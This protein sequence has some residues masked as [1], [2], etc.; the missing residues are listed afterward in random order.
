MSNV[1][2]EFLKNDGG[3]AEGLS[4]A[5]IE[6]FRENPVSAVARETGQNSR[7]ARFCKTKPVLVKIDLL[8]IETKEFPSIAEYRQATK[9]CLEKSVKNSKKKETEFFRKASKVLESKNLRILKIADYNTTGVPGPCEEG[10][11]FHTLAKTDGISDKGKTGSLGSFGIGKNA[12]YALSDIQ[13]VFYSTLYYNKSNK[14]EG[15]FLCMGKTQYI[16]HKDENG[17]DRRRKGYWGLSEKYLPLTDVNQVPSWLRREE[18]GTSIFSIASRKTENWTYEMVVAILTNFFVAV[19]RDEMKFVISRGT[20]T[21]NSENINNWF[22]NNK[23]QNEVDRLNCKEAFEKAKILHTCLC[24]KEKIIEE[25][26]IEQLGKFNLHLLLREGLQNTVGIIRNGMYITDNLA[27]FDE[28]FK[29]FP[30]HKDFA[31]IVEP[32]TPDVSDKL[33]WMENPRHDNLSAD[34]IADEVKRK[35]MRVAIKTLAKRIREFL[36]RHARVRPANQQKIDELNEFFVSAKTQQEDEEGSK[37]DPK[38]RRVTKIERS[39]NVSTVRTTRPGTPFE[40]EDN[41]DN[42]EKQ[43]NATGRGKGEGG[44]KG[45]KST[46]KPKII[47]VKIKNERITIPDLQNPNYRNIFFTPTESGELVVIVTMTGLSKPERLFA[48]D[49]TNGH[50]LSGTILIK[51]TSSERISLLVE[52]ESDY[53]GPVEITVY[54][55]PEKQKN[56]NQ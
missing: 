44:E 18:Q 50:V 17:I 28:P 45:G 10:N 41:N 8:T 55:K 34:R 4:D 19:S 25:L 16:S 32:K 42:Y 51:A 11:P 30:M 15:K 24:D 39:E 1:K 40:E 12:P 14:A 33:K 5:G 23:I 35:T 53:T 7:D 43:E 31:L 13:T 52:F 49:V 47:P 22:E 27:Y 21:I 54:K 48:K 3:E 2:L 46:T 9:H 56:E 37:T 29:R 26:T 20:H 36:A 38:Q 6:T